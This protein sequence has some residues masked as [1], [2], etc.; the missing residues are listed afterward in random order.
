MGSAASSIPDKASVDEFKT[1]AGENFSQE[2]FDENKDGEGNVTKDQLI[3]YRAKVSKCDRYKI[4]NPNGMMLMEVYT[5][6]DDLCCK[7]K[8]PRTM[9]TG[10]IDT[11]G[12]KMVSRGAYKSDTIESYLLELA[13]GSGYVLGWNTKYGGMFVLDMFVTDV[14]ENPIVIAP[15]AEPIKPKPDKPKASEKPPDDAAAAIQRAAKAKAER[16][17]NPPAK[18]EPKKK[19]KPTPTPTS[20]SE[21]EPISDSMPTAAEPI[22]A[23]S[24]AA[25]R[26]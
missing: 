26:E 15:P 9:I 16:A 10:C 23:D 22:T 14:D 13:D 7:V 18:P 2:W 25:E 8:E 4:K 6:N 24:V 12:K 19:K 1:L 11:V 3:A 20:E 5:K 17:K 21:S